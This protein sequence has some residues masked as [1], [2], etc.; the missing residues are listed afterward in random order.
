VILRE[1]SKR[2]PAALHPV[3]M[4][5]ESAPVVN[6]GITNHLPDEGRHMSY[7]GAT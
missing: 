2:K 4:R 7:L 1:F 6:D 5:R 3:G